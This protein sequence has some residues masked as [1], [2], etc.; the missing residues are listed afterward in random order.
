MQV[1]RAFGPFPEV[2]A[3]LGGCMLDARFDVRFANQRGEKLLQR[4][5]HRLLFQRPSNGVA[6]QSSHAETETETETKPEG[7]GRSTTR[8][9]DSGSFRSAASVGS[10]RSSTSSTNCVAALPTHELLGAPPSAG[11]PSPSAPS[12]VPSPSASHGSFASPSRHPS[13][14]S[15]PRLDSPSSPRGGFDSPRTALAASS[16][17][18]TS[19]AATSTGLVSSASSSTSVFSAAE[20]DAHTAALSGALATALDAPAPA[21]GASAPLRSVVALG[22]VSL[23]VRGASPPPATPPLEL[24]IELQP[25]AVSLAFAQ[26][27]LS[28]AGSCASQRSVASAAS[29][30]SVD[31]GV[32]V[33]FPRLDARPVTRPRASLAYYP[34]AEA[35]A[36]PRSQPRARADETHAGA[37]GA[38]SV[39]EL[40]A[41]EAQLQAQM[42]QIRLQLHQF[43]SMAEAS[44]AMQQPLRDSGY[45]SDTVAQ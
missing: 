31:V 44:T 37:P 17:S 22:D 43:A 36:P 2:E 38:A 16:M 29:A 39:R 10:F 14:A 8:S 6:T 9:S 20:A 35:E 1:A 34:P 40:V 21:H 41:M 23:P 11:V 30:A 19:A 7:Q 25:S 26:Q 15:P 33:G 45:G 42:A 28:P 4:N 18:A 24:A 27:C 13:G 32:G 12:T 5:R 3:L